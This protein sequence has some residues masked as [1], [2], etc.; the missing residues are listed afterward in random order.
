[1]F[2]SS[3][4]H[5]SFA[6][7]STHVVVASSQLSLLMQKAPRKYKE[8]I[9]MRSLLAENS[10]TMTKYDEGWGRALMLKLVEKGSSLLRR[11]PPAEPPFFL[12]QPRFEPSLVREMLSKADVN[13]TD[14]RVNTKR[15]TLFCGLRCCLPFGSPILA[16]FYNASP[17]HKQQLTP[18]HNQ[19]FDRTWC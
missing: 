8:V 19:V 2:C 3:F 11:V 4:R 15:S 16:G 5:S 14:D 10:N 13:E 7:V 18:V 6:F 9:F 1:M 17:C 12:L